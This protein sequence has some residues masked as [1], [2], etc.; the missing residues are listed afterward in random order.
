M[1]GEMRSQE[2]EGPLTARAHAKDKKRLTWWKRFAHKTF[3]SV[4]IQR[5]IPARQN[6]AIKPF[7]WWTTSSTSTHYNHTATIM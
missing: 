1:Q 4:W 7:K 5:I 2:M 3:F 6:P